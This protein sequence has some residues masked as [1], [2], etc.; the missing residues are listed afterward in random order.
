MEPSFSGDLDM[1]NQACNLLENGSDDLRCSTSHGENNL[2]EQV[3]RAYVL[4][5]NQIDDNNCSDDKDTCFSDDEGM[6]DITKLMN[7]YHDEV[8]NHFFHAVEK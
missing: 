7:K 6:P 3:D 2:P 8:R 5:D 1:S 4:G